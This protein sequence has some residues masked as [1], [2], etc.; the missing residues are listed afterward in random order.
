MK[1]VKKHVVGSKLTILVLYK[2]LSTKE[3]TKVNVTLFGI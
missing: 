2:Y 3:F 1:H